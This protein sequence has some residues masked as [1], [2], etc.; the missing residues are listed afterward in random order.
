MRAYLKANVLGVELLGQRVSF[1]PVI[2]VRH[3]VVLCLSD[4]EPT[5]PPIS[6]HECP[7]HLRLAT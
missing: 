6:S 4:T 2:T 5:Y 3:I 1:V 7:V